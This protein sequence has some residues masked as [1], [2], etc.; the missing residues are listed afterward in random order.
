MNIKPQIAFLNLIIEC[1]RPNENAYLIKH[2]KRDIRHIKFLAEHDSDR[3]AEFL[4]YTIFSD[5]LNGEV[6]FQGAI[7]SLCLYY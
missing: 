6:D 3:L 7:A 1:C 5:F 4:A 2:I